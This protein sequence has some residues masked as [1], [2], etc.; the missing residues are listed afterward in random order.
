[1]RGLEC[2]FAS[3]LARVRAY[4]RI[5]VCRCAR[6]CVSALVCACIPACV[7]VHVCSCVLSRVLVFMRASVCADERASVYQA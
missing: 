5:F 4:L 2:E 1:M 6:V 7:L 3:F